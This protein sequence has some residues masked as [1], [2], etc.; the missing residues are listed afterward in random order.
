MSNILKS[1]IEATE[2]GEHFSEAID[3]ASA[4]GANSESGLRKGLTQV[5]L[6]SIEAFIL[7]HPLLKN[8]GYYWESLLGSQEIE[9][10]RALKK[11]IGDKPPW[12]LVLYFSDRVESIHSR[13][14]LRKITE[15]VK[16]EVLTQLRDSGVE[17][18]RCQT[19]GFHFTVGD[20]GKRAPLIAGLGLVLDSN[21]RAR[22]L[23]D[24]LKPPRRP[25]TKPGKDDQSY[26]TLQ[27]DHVVPRVGL[28][29]T[30]AT[31]LQVM[32]ALCN[33]GKRCYR[34][35]YEGISSLV[36]MSLIRPYGDGTNYAVLEEVFSAAIRS[37]PV[38]TVTGKS[39]TETELTVRPRNAANGNREWLF[40]WDLETI[41]YEVHDPTSA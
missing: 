10:E 6:R 20:V 4:L 21:I 38:C 28:G 19:C 14:H 8:I 5:A 13:S 15:T 35:P 31:N 3:I 23:A 22:R 40:P 26:T 2:P 9:V 7:G 29:A 24:K 12:E 17:E 25:A 30:N 32:C 41:S 1:L 37:N 39:S 16:E 33:F 27:F 36:S 11:I 18:L 34:F